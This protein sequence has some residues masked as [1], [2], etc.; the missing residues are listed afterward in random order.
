MGKM[1]QR[2]M[3]AARRAIESMYTGTCVV[4]E[5]Q[6]VT[7]P[8]TKKTG[9]QEVTVLLNQPCRLS[10]KSNPSTGEGE[11]AE[12]V[13]EIKLFISPDVTIKEGSK[14]EVTQNG[15]TTAYSRSGVPAIYET[16]QEITLG[17]YQRKA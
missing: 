15:V 3:N 14:I 13:Q 16:H 8:V 10:F 9:F 2:A 6:K 12:T 17:L 7:D 11:T 4:I 5:Q 1:M